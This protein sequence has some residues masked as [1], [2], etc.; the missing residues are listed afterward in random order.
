MH[1][2]RMRW[3]VEFGVRPSG[4]PKMAVPF[5]AKD[6]PVERAEYGHPDVAIMLM[7]LSYYKS[8]LSDEQ[9]N[10]KSYIASFIGH[11]NIQISK[12]RIPHSIRVHLFHEGGGQVASY[13]RTTQYL[14]HTFDLN[15][16]SFFG[17]REE[18]KNPN[19]PAWIWNFPLHCKHDRHFF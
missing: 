9:E 8:G 5:R 15:D 19:F 3:R 14:R 13:S 18:K 6:V 7:Q 1:A 11:R 12:S 16:K 17:K 2:L 10:L 4:R